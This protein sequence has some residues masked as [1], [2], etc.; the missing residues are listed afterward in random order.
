MHLLVQ[1]PFLLMLYRGTASCASLSCGCW[2]WLNLQAA[3]GVNKPSV[4]R[5]Q[6]QHVMLGGLQHR[7]CNRGGLQS[8]AVA[9]LSSS[10]SDMQCQ[11]EA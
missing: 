9:E 6:Q 7:I 1:L 5:M 10:N 3:E 11:E 8:S 2:R 4:C